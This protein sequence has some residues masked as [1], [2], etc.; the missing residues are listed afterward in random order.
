[1]ESFS[2]FEG[3]FADS[4]RVDMMV[5]ELVLNNGS[6]QSWGAEKLEVQSVFQMMAMISESEAKFKELFCQ[7]KN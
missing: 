3:T 1:M 6:K 4:S 5:G 7:W 2:R